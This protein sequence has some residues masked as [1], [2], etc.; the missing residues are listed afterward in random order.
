MA[1]TIPPARPRFVYVPALGPGLRALLMLIFTCVAFLGATGVYMLAIRVFEWVKGGTVQTE[2]SLWMTLLHVLVGG[3]LILPFLLF[4]FTH[5]FTA[6]KRPNRVAVRLGIILFLFSIAVGISGLLLVRIKDLPQLHIPTDSAAYWIIWGLHVV[7]PILA[8]FAYVWHRM[9]GPRI[10]W[11]WGYAWG[12]SVAVF[13]GVMLG[14]HTSNP[15]LWFAKGS[16][17]GEKYYEPSRSRTIDGNFIS[18]HTL[19]LDEYCLKCH[20]DAY[21]S[22]QKSM[23]RHSS[24]N[25]PAYLFSVKETRQI[26]GVRASRWCAGCHDPVP[27]FSG[28]FD[29]PTYDMEN[30]PTAKAAITCVVCHAMTNVNSRS[31]NGDYTIAEPELYPF[32]FS[33]N[34]V[35]QYI[36][37]QL[38]LAKPELHKKAFLKPFHRTEAFCSTCH[39]VGLPQEVNHYKEFLRGQNHNDSFLLSGVSGHGSRSFYYPPVAKTKCADCHMDL[40]ESN[41]FGARDFDGSGK[42]SIHN[43][44]FLGANTAVPVLVKHPQTEQMIEETKAF[45]LGGIDGKSPTL[46]V[47]LFGLKHLAQGKYTGVDAPLVDDQPLRPNLP[48]LKPGQPYLFEVVV[49][50]LNMGHHFTQG[51]VDSNEVWVD[52]EVKSGGK[53]I[54]RSGGMS[55]DDEGKVDENAHFI[56]VLMLDR[57]GNRIDRRNP[58][59]IFTPLYNHQIP[60]GAANVVHYRVELPKDLAANVEV[61]ARVRY[62]KFDDPYMRHVHGAK[63][64]DERSESR[65]SDPKVPKLPIIDLCSDKVVLPVEGV[66]EQVPPQE[67]PIPAKVRWQ[68]WNDYGIACFLEGGPDGNKGG[69]LGMAE[70]A[71]ARLLTPEFKDFPEARAHGHL[72]LARVHLAYGGDD[73]LEMAREAL[74]KAKASEPPAPWQTVAFFSGRTNLLLRNIPEAIANFQQLLDPA[75]RDPVRKFDFTK[76]YVAINELG[77]TF[78]VAAQEEEGRAQAKRDDFLRKAVAEFEKTLKIDAEDVTAHEFLAKCYARLGDGGQPA[79]ETAPRS[80]AEK[81]LVQAVARLNDDQASRVEIARAILAIVNAEKGIRPGVLAE[82]HRD[83]LDAFNAGGNV[84]DRLALSPAIIKLDHMLLAAVPDRAKAFTSAGGDRNRAAAELDDI[85][86]RLNQRPAQVDVL[87]ALSP[88]LGFPR[89]GLPSSFALSGMALKGHLQ[90]PLPAPRLLT[91]YAVRPGIHKLFHDEP[92]AKLRAAAAQA[93]GSMHRL[94]H[95]IFKQDDNAADV[96]VQR[97]R[98]RF[99]AAAR[100]SQSIVIYDLGS[101]SHSDSVAAGR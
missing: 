38:I 1:T 67:S 36:N 58:Q 81:Q 68:R 12:G 96:A 34:A 4:G 63:P 39:K 90:G 64:R 88:A 92:D 83:T 98:A 93:L 71:F 45:L 48:K 7:T 18:A 6:Y 74:A 89:P 13:V 60:P 78:F 55:G 42:R 33:D 54:A 69:E 40:V 70:A 101:S 80:A 22:H 19:M 76:D 3:V 25:N 99:P 77:K 23:H 31:G 85:L 94:M 14:M 53:T 97:Y 61:S 75:N 29:D 84:N 15:R 95:G 21:D 91:L 73:R 35:L 52:F 17:E 10:K 57:H 43:H 50:T 56:N 87:P 8:V 46:R 9:A 27:F 62:R 16:P 49:R 44:Q 11:N 59:D 65:G 86:A 28:Q 79:E 5:L 66:A 82:A 47:D 100:A 26:A 41:D 37:N 24:F 2:F 72:N 30:H 20:Q 51:T 32:T